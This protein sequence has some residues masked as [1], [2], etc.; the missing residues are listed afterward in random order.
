MKVKGVWNIKQMPVKYVAEL[1]NGELA[2]FNI[3]PFR[4]VSADELT[5]FKGHHPICQNSTAMPEYL[6]RFYDLESAGAAKEG[7]KKV[8]KML[9][10]EWA[11]KNGIS[12]VTARQKAQKGLL[13]TAEKSGKFW[14]IDEDEPN[15]DNR[16]R[17]PAP[18][19]ERRIK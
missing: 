1:E 11:K 3:V 17:K 10:S 19:G 12:D 2:T 15:V 13:E 14:L 6:Y 16:T 4:T 5:P 9:L 8:K 7:Y 18:A